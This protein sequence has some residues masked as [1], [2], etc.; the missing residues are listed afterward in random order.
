ML[1]LRKPFT[2][3][4]HSTHSRRSSRSS[5]CRFRLV[6]QYTLCCQEQTS[7]RS[8]I[9]QSYTLYL[10]RVYDTSLT[11]ILVDILTG[12]V[13]KVTLALAYLINNY[14]ALA[15]CIG[16][17]LAQRLLD[18]TLYDADTCCLI[19]VITL[20]IL[21]CLEST[22][23]SSTTTSNDTFLDSCTGSAESIV[24]TILLFLHLNL[25]V[26]TYIKDSYTTGELSQ[27]L[28]KFLLII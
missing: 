14:R 6:N 15:T 22:D 27:T 18:S 13:T 23:I 19:S 5:R 3:L 8:C 4:H 26:G 1:C 10:S 28:L 12:I 2:R 25:R 9:F 11:H 24:N 16:Y 21:Q 20:H 7:N 17:N